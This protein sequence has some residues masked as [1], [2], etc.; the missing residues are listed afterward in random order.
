MCVVDARDGP[1]AYHVEQYGCQSASPN[2]KAAPGFCIGGNMNNQARIM[3]NWVRQY[4]RER[5]GTLNIA[6]RLVIVG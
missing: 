1:L 3:S 2:G 6:T 4:V 5:G